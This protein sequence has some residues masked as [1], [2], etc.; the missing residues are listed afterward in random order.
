[1]AAVASS[2]AEDVGT[3]CQTPYGD[4]IYSWQQPAQ[5]HL[6]NFPSLFPAELASF[7]PSVIYL[8][9][10]WQHLHLSPAAV[11]L[12]GS[13]GVGRAGNC[14]CLNFCCPLWATLPPIPPPPPGLPAA[15]CPAA[16]GWWLLM[17]AGTLSRASF[18][19]CVNALLSRATQ[20]RA[21]GLPSFL[22]QKTS[23]W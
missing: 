19:F 14:S 6:S 18:P 15:L 13:V 16:P 9:V 4:L 7:F 3:Y 2:C 22:Q 17:R 10:T 8:A 23:F 1:M 20:T 12:L 21:P 11:T 5:P